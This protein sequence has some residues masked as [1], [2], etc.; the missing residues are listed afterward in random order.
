MRTLIRLLCYSI[1]VALF[2]GCGSKE[3]ALPESLPEEISSVLEEDFPSFDEES[4]AIEEVSDESSPTAHVWQ[5]LDSYGGEVS[6]YAT[7]SYVLV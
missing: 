3:Q 4:P 2:V 7:Y 5:Y 6:G 1:V